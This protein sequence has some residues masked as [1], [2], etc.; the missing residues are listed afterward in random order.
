MPRPFTDTE[1]SAIRDRLLAAGQE[2]FAQRGIRATTVEQLARAAGI[3][4]GA[5][6][7]FYAAKEQ[8]F[9]AI[10]AQVETALQARLETQVAEAPHDA[11]RLLLRASLQARDENPL[12]DVAI[13]EE[14][15]SVLRTMSPDEREAFL[16]RDVE[17]TESIAALLHESGVT[18]TASP[19]LLAGLLR[20]M[21]F[22][23]MHRDD[24]GAGI[25]PAVEDFLVDALTD[26]LAG[27]H[28]RGAPKRGRSRAREASS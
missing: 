14:A 13:S 27:E 20:A 22:V 19:T 25:A 23:G 21:V 10:V 12:F 16:R 7:Q 5:F 2:L 8:L 6:Y 26:A 11:L 15:V 1:R 9:F 4:K 3:S 17:M 28:K 18:L 24:V